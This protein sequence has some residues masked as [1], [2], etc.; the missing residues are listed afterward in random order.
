MGG[1]KLRL[2]EKQGEEREA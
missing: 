1:R 2:H